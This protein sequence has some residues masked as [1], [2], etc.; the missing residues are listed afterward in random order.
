MA[1]ETPDIEKRE[2]EKKEPKLLD[3]IREAARVRHLSLKT[4]KAYV[5]WAGATA[6]GADR[7]ARDVSHLAPLL[8]HPPPD[9]RLRHPDG[10]GAPGAQERPDHDDLHPRAQPR[11]TGSPESGGHFVT[12]QLI[13]RLLVG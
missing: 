2:P 7:E 6:E 10:A 1:I 9:E 5:H 13:R 4:E 12:W 3:R 8:C 11:R